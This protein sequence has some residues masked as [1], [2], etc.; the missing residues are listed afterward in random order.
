VKN[1][2]HLASKTTREDEGNDDSEISSQSGES[3]SDDEEEAK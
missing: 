3:F 2:K 1:K